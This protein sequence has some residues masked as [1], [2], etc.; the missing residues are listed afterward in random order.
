LF[1]RNFSLLK[2]GA[3]VSTE[4]FDIRYYQGIGTIHFF[5]KNK[6]VVD[7]LNR[8]VGKERQWLPEDDKSA[9]KEFWA[10]YNDAEKITKS[11]VIPKYYH[12]NDGK[13]EAIMA[14]HLAACDQL[15]YDT[16]NLLDYEEKEAA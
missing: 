15:G 2:N 12:H 10:Q 8:L 1:D 9:P 16:A 13:D 7:R 6:A 11:M 5:P 3:R 14:A 4:Y